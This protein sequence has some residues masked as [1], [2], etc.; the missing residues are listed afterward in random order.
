[1]P[2]TIL[3]AQ[4][5]FSWHFTVAV[6]DSYPPLI[7]SKKPGNEASLREGG[8]D[9]PLNP[10]LVFFFVHLG[11][12]ILQTICD[13]INLCFTEKGRQST[14]YNANGRKLWITDGTVDIFTGTCL[15]FLRFNVQKAITMANIHQVQ[16]YYYLQSTTCMLIS[17]EPPPPPPPSFRSPLSSS[18]CTSF[19]C[20]SSVIQYT[21][22]YS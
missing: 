14:A 16:Y 4:E 8:Y 10:P 3:G 15:F 6:G 20:T 7:P 1:M 12:R 13:R 11:M 19:A 9:T 18:L 2:C 21:S 17:E 22:L 5:A